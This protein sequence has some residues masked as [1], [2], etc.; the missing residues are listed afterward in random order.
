MGN[1]VLL[2]GGE[3]TAATDDVMAAALSGVA[4][5]LVIAMASAYEQPAHVADACVAQMERLGAQPRVSAAMKRADAFDEAIVAEVESAHAVVMTDGSS[6]HLRSALKDSPLWTAVV[7]LVA[8]GGCLVLSGAAAMV[9]TDPMF[10]E[11]GGAFTLGLGLVTPL[12]VMAKHDTWTP[13]RSRRVRELA[14][15]QAPVVA[16][17]TAA[18]LMWTNGI[19]TSNGAVTITAAGVAVTLEELPQPCW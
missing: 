18:A 7:G 16:L 11:R 2:G 19:W 3:G 13:E 12:A 17:D 9:A 1:L 5:V 6:M 4:H 8:R 15:A 14:P 10:D